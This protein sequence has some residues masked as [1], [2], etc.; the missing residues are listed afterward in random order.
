V[1]HWTDS[2]QVFCAD[3]GSIA[4]GKFAWARRLEGEDDELHVR[5]SIKSL[6]EAVVYQLERGRPVALGFEAPLFIPVPEDDAALGKARPCDVDAPAW[7]S[8]IGGSVMATGLAQA[9]WLLR[10]VRQRVPDTDLHLSWDEF[11][12]ARS[13]LLIWE[14]FVTRDAKGDTDEQDAINGLNAFCGQ[15]PTPGDANAAETERPLSLA[16]AAAIWA[17]WDVSPAALRSACV[18][19]RALAV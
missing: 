13:G 16:A 1:A 12:A 7:S 14:A 19:V 8:S 10:Y 6:A 9:A 4:R 5:S 18:L 3:I 17:G 2:L 11:A 15:L